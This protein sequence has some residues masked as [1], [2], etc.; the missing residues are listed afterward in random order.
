MEPLLDEK[1]KEVYLEFVEEAT[2]EEGNPLL[3][4]E[5]NPVTTTTKVTQ[6]A[7]V[8]KTVVKTENGVIAYDFSDSRFYNNRGIHSRGSGFTEKN[9]KYA[10]SDSCV[11]AHFG[12][13]QNPE[14]TTVRVPV[15]KNGKWQQLPVIDEN[16]EYVLDENGNVTWEF[17][18]EDKDTV[19]YDVTDEE[20]LLFMY[21]KLI[22]EMALETAF[23]G[24]RF[25]DLSRLATALGN[26]EFFARRVAASEVLT[27]DWRTAEGAEGWNGELY[28]RLLDKNNWYLPL[29]D[30]YLDFDIV[31]VPPTDPV[32]PEEDDTTGDDVVEGGDIV[33]GGDDIVEGG[34]VVVEGEVETTNP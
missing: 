19:L 13:D 28:G 9:S 6:Y 16:K 18:Y 14:H 8:Y 2:D 31:P 5:G 7:P 10:L 21:D 22:D 15:I 20:R 30:N 12:K 3:D 27:G 23:E 26:P 1:G 33:E 17:V 11:A 29:P 34:D 25:G 24:N 4:E 32:L